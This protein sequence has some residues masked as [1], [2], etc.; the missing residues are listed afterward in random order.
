MKMQKMVIS[1]RKKVMLGILIIG[2]LV[3]SLMLYLA[4]NN[5]TQTSNEAANGTFIPPPSCKAG[6]SEQSLIVLDDLGDVFI[7]VP[8][9]N[10]SVKITE[11][12]I[13][14][15]EQDYP[16]LNYSDIGFLEQILSSNDNISIL[17]NNPFATNITVSP[18]KGYKI[19][20]PNSTGEECAVAAART[21]YKDASNI[22]LEYL[23]YTVVPYDDSAWLYYNESLPSWRV[24]VNG[25]VVSVIWID[26]DLGILVAEMQSNAMYLWAKVIVGEKQ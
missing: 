17:E 8:V 13:Y 21:L 4:Y 22:Y 1:Y 2:V 10:G 18:S 16:D 23:G 12:L 5:E 20:L 25:E 11:T 19:F 7:V 6:W 24:Y 14:V 3:A 15:L 26:P 9:G